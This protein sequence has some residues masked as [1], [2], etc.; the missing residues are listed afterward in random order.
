MSKYSARNV[1]VCIDNLLLLKC[2]NLP[3]AFKVDKK[4][5]LGNVSYG[6]Q[7]CVCLCLKCLTFSR[8]LVCFAMNFNFGQFGCLTGDFSQVP[9]L[10]TGS[11]PSKTG[12]SGRFG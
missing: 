3:V 5:E 6:K 7:G 12:C 10:A 1:F 8:V 11:P 9:S 2:M 4:L